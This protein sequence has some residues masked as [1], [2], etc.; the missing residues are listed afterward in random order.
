MMKSGLCR[1]LPF[2]CNTL[3]VQAAVVECCVI[4]ARTRAKKA[5]GLASIP[6]LGFCFLT[7]KWR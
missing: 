2:V 6:S 7:S 3:R 4:L 1:I 5:R